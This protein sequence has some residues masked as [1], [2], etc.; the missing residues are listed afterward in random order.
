M[1]GWRHVRGT[2][3][4][5]SA[6]NVLFV[7]LYYEARKTSRTMAFACMVMPRENSISSVGSRDFRIF[8]T[9]YAKA[10][11]RSGCEV[12]YRHKTAD[13]LEKSLQEAAQNVRQ[14]IKGERLTYISLY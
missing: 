9:P 8:L 6:F 5:R 11:N 12:L 10:T 2:S 13:E 3:T 1:V 14:D 4:V 7:V